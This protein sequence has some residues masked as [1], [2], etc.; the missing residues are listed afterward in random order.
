MKRH[1][2]FD[3]ADVCQPVLGCHTESFFESFGF[4]LDI[5]FIQRTKLFACEV[6]V[7]FTRPQVGEL[8]R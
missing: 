2:P 8:I 3:D 5:H 6:H 1:V 4:D 7:A